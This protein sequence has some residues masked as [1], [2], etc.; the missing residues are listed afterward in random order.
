[1]TGNK[2]THTLRTIREEFDDYLLDDGNT[3]RIKEVLVGFGFTDKIE[4]KEGKAIAKAF[5]NVKQIVGIIPT[6]DVDTGNLETT[7]QQITTKDRIEKID[8]KPLKT[9]LNFYETDEFLIIVR[10]KL[11]EIWTTRFKDPNNVPIYSINSQS[12]VDAPN[13]STLAQFEEEST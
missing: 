13:K 5:F 6:A 9:S 10:S 1:M 11:N 3:L 7:T 8:F 2:I 12:S 4:K